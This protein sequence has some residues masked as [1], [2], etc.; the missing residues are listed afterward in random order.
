MFI[1][2]F[3]ALAFAVIGF[4]FGVPGAMFGAVIGLTVGAYIGFGEC[5]GPVYR[6]FFAPKPA[7]EVEVPTLTDAV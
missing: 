6:F 3:V 5:E 4:A 2:I 7:K 1:T